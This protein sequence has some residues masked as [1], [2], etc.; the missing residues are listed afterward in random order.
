MNAKEAYAASRQTLENEP[1]Y[2]AFIDKIN[3]KINEAIK[4]GMFTASHE[5]S[6]NEWYKY[7]EIIQHYYM[8]LGYY[9]DTHYFSG[10]LRLYWGD[11]K[12]N[13]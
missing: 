12:N 10:T 13:Q 7:V 8:A 2:K 6:S 5:F 11:F 1:E 9:T 3:Q 4:R